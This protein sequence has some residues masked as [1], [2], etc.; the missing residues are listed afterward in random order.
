MYIVLHNPLSKNNKSKRTTKKVVDYFKA[1]NIPFRVKSILKIK[2][3]EAYIKNTDPE[4]KILILGGDGTINTFIN[5]TFKT[6]IS[7]EIY[8]MRSGSGNDFL[9]TLSLHQTPSQNIIELRHNQAIRYFING[10]GLGIDGAIANLVNQSKNKNQFKYFIS[11]IKTFLTYKPRYLE[12]TIDG[13]LYRF[14]K[15]YLIN[16]NN[17]MFIGGGMQIT[18]KAKLDD[19]LLDVVIVHS[20]SRLMLLIIFITVYFGKHLRFK[21]YVFFKNAKHVKA[22]MFSKQVAQCDG[23][24][25]ENTNEIEVRLTKKVAN[26]KTFKMEK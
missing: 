24:C 21:K 25:F 8:L 12:A 16:V 10:S 15:A 3:L 23:E 14:K 2:D 11:T 26:F 9:R 22:T 20:I 13:E 18:P 17:G 6:A 7:H 5:K 19:D 4:A 1:K